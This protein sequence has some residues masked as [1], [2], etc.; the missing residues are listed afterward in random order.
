[1]SV[2][3]KTVDSLSLPSSIDEYIASCAP[4]VRPVLAE[5]RRV[6]KVAVPRATETISYNMPA[7]KLRRSFFYFAA[8]KKH[9][10]VYPPMTSDP[11][12]AT[13]LKP[14]ANEKGNLRF[15][16]AEPIPYELIARVA[17][18]LSNQYSK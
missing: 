16:L 8:Y 2:E 7:L 10:G 15:S 1:M 17:V 14:Y 5:I 9:I 12:L 18:A 4:A 11:A 13:D 6:A 3:R